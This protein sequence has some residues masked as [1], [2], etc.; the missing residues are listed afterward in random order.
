MDQDPKDRIEK[1]KSKL[2]SRNYNP[3]H[4]G[5]RTGFEQS[6]TRGATDW[7]SG[8]KIPELL[9]QSAENGSTSVW[10]KRIFASSLIFFVIAAGIAI[11]MFLGGLN[12]VSTKNV[13]IEVGGPISIAAGEPNEF[14]ISIKNSNNVALENV[15]L[16]VI[17]PEGARDTNTKAPLTSRERIPLENIPSGRLLRQPLSFIAYGEKDSVQSLK[18]ALEYTVTGSNATFVKEKIHEVTISSAPLI[19]DVSYPSEVSSGQLFQFKID[20]S[21]N[22]TADMENVVLRVESPFGFTIESAQPEMISQ[23][24]WNIGA[25]KPA[26]KKTILLSGR[27]QGQDNDERSFRFYVG[28]ATA[29]GQDIETEI[30]SLIETLAIKRSFI[31]LQSTIN[32]NRGEEIVLSGG[33][34]NNATIR[35][36][37]ATGDK[38]SDLVIEARIAGAPLDR[39]SISVTNGFYQSVRDT[40]VWDKSTLPALGTIDVGEEGELRFNFDTKAGAFNESEG[41]IDIILTA[42]ASRATASGR[43]TVASEATQKIRLAANLG[44]SGRAVY[45]V[46]P[47]ENTGPIPPRAE[48]STTYT[49]LL[50]TTASFGDV[51]GV[52]ARAKL[53]PSVEWLGVVSPTSESV[54]FDQ[55]SRVLTWNL[56]TVREGTGTTRSARELAFQVRITPSV[57][58]VGRP[59]VLVDEV[60]ILGQDSRAGT[61]L[62]DQV[63]QITTSISTDPQYNQTDGLITQ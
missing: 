43:E 15:H 55:G 28:T 52:V 50:S 57:N 6:E 37:N 39:S 63:G 12:A 58:Q 30:F 11:Y 53:P 41:V 40:I 25:L 7:Q 34:F 3:S 51:T 61:S 18:L 47:F 29:D 62:I 59:G 21:S 49:I 45:S 27:L 44:L 22:T 26:E 1:I 10:P 9:A 24:V 5:K 13:D 14:E 16:L 2:Y 60:E 17:Y 32:G 54:K 42:R 46:G 35:W 38:L 8:N 36:Q 4:V 19:V 20:V 31:T 56:G 23:N 33:R 48:Q